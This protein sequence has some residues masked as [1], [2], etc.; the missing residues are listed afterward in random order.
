MSAPITDRFP[1]DLAPEATS[2]NAYAVTSRSGPHV[3]MQAG[4]LHAGRF[5][6]TTSR[7]SLKARSVRSHEVASA[8][9]P[10]G[11][12]SHLVSGRTSAINAFDPRSLI[13]DLTAPIRAPGAVLRLG[14]DQVEQ[15]VG[16]LEASAEI[17]G[18]WLPHRRVLLVTKPD[19]SLTLEGFD[20]VDVGGRWA[21]RSAVTS[22][23]LVITS[24]RPAMD[25]LPLDHLPG[26]HRPV[27][28]LDSRVHLG[29]TTPEG[30][31]ALP[32]RWVG[33][34][35]F[36][37]SAAALAIVTAGLPGRAVAVF[38]QSTSRRPD[39]KLGAMFR[40]SAH[41]VDIDGPRAVVTLHTERITTW[42]G[43]R[44]STITVDR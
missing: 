39:E 21:D 42:D 43:F 27:V 3:T 19:Q 32:A 1:A 35:R 29:V 17:P 16:Y 18:D 14:L 38:D 8:I 37:T 11:D 15:L 2:F 25:D 12:E 20:V 44:A 22:D 33:E 30:P 23:A 41:V 5:W 24:A 9:V 13:S 40:G 6:T 34:S 4:V 28:R 36:I 7:T 10:R 31:I 26:S